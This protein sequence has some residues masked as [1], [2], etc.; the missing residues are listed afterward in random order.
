MVL[1]PAL[2]VYAVLP[3][4]A[5]FYITQVNIGLFFVLAVSSLGVFGVVM[6]GWASNSKYSLLGALRSAAQM[7][8]YEIFLASPSS[9]R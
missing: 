7:L 2:V 1:V 6:A 5:T 8:S 9:G 3:F 4:S